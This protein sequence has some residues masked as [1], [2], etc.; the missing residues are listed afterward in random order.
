MERMRTIECIWAMVH[1]WITGM[2]QMIRNFWLDSHMETTNPTQMI[3]YMR[4][5]SLL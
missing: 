5:T 2:I 4:T 3:E 1:I